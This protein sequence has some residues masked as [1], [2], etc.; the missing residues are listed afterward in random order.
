M[1]DPIISRDPMRMEEIFVQGK[2][3]G[4]A[5]TATARDG[6]HA[7]TIQDTYMIPE[8]DQVWA[9]EWMQLKP[10]WGPG[11]IMEAAAAMN[12]ELRLARAIVE[13]VDS[14]PA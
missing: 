11:L 12:I 13:Y 3:C 2:F 8:A 1:A 10:T 4:V 14:L 6:D 7:I 9:E 5:I